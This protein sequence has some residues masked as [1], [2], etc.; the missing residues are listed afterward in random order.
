M[1]KV[2]NSVI[3]I[4]GTRTEIMAECVCLCQKIKEALGEDDYKLILATA[5]KSDEELVAEADALKKKILEFVM[6]CKK[7]DK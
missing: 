5:E 6:G 3:E 1:I 7:G 2:S 4:N